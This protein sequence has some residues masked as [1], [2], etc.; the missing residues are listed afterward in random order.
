MSK[1]AISFANE[2]KL[3]RDSFA[4]EC[5]INRIVDQYARTGMVNHLPRVEPQYGEAPDMSFHEAACLNARLASLEAEGALETL[6]EQ[7]SDPEPA[8]AASAPETPP[9]PDP[10][11]SPAD[12]E[13]SG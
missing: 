10:D 5:D 3:T 1:Y 12:G 6:G 13:S 11:P 9:G 7:K 8:E 4:E 2:Q